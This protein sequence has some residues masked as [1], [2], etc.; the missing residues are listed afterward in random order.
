MALIYLNALNRILCFD[1]D[2]MVPMAN[3]H[4]VLGLIW[5]A[6]LVVTIQFVTNA[7]IA[8]V[9]H[10]HDRHAALQQSSV[11]ERA[12]AAQRIFDNQLTEQTA[13]SNTIETVLI[14]ASHRAEPAGASANCIGGCCGSGLG[15]C[16]AAAIPGF[17]LA[18]PRF[19]STAR[20]IA[21]KPANL[22]SIDPEGLAKP[23][24]NLA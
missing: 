12:T 3:R 7:A 23:P 4:R 16:S 20:V 14:A 15:C 9:G 1:C 2:L 22:G 24:K 13:K 5:V 18:L 11:T 21:F 17:W 6:I 10:H 8:H 19:D